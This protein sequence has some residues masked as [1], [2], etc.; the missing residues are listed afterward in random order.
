[1]DTVDDLGVFY[2]TCLYAL[3]CLGL[4]LLNLLLHRVVFLHILRNDTAKVGR[5]VE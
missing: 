1:M 4:E 3:Y 5:I 2:E